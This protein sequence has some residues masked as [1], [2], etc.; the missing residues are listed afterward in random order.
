MTGVQT[1]ALPILVRRV[2][3]GHDTKGKAVVAS[4]E[5]ITSV[6]RRIG[7]NITGCEMW[8]TDRMPVDNSEQA[9]AAQLESLRAERLNIDRVR[10]VAA[11]ATQ[12]AIILIEAGIGERTILWNHDP[13]LT[14][15]ADQLRK[16]DILDARLLHLDGCDE[17]AAL[18]AA[19]WAK[20]AG[21]PVVIDID[22]LYG[23]S[24][25]TLLRNVDHLIAAD[26]FARRVTGN[27]AP[28]QAAKIGR[29]HV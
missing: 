9:G 16:E 14:F 15:P 25:H 4:D 21:I 7:A 19:I 17:E 28:E 20:A 11:A 18:Q 6:S 2:V 5:R 3:T 1:C 13:S 10:T 27:V 23:D 26:D 29:A 12:S 22:E 8:S 24:T